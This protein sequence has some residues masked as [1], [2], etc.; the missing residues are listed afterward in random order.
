MYCKLYNINGRSYLIIYYQFIRN[1]AIYWIKSSVYWPSRTSH[2]KGRSVSFKST[3]SNTT[4]TASI[5]TRRYTVTLLKQ[6]TILSDKALAP[7]SGALRCRLDDIL[8]HLSV[9]NDNPEADYQ[10]YYWLSKAKYRAQIIK[11]ITCNA[12][13]WLPCYKNFPNFVV[14]YANEIVNG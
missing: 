4:S 9:E 1:V 8:S 13:L 10:M 14:S 7:Y 6:N 5:I 3:A 12:A 11:C 2:E